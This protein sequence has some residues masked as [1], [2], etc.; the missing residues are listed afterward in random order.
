[1]FKG[2]SEEE[3][4]E[5]EGTNRGSKYFDFSFSDLEKCAKY[6][7][8]SNNRRGEKYRIIS[9]ELSQKL[10]QLYSEDKSVY[11]PPIK[12]IEI[13]SKNSPIGPDFSNFFSWWVRIVKKTFK[14]GAKV[15][16]DGTLLLPH[17]L[18]SGKSIWGYAH[19]G[20]IF[21]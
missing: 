6:N 13:D 19:A 3:K 2:F 9:V 10:H 1:M 7:D 5:I 15:L 18:P 16:L 4:K 21:C 11:V 20:F 12:F 14:E 17:D 8:E